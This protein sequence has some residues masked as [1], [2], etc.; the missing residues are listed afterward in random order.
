MNEFEQTVGCVEAQDWI[1]GTRIDIT[2]ASTGVHEHIRTCAEC[3]E[4]HS[5]RG[6]LSVDLRNLRTELNEVPPRS[7]DHAVLAAAADAVAARESGDH[8]PVQLRPSAPPPVATPRWMAAAAALLGA[9][10][11]LGFVAGRFTATGASGFAGGVAAPGPY[12]AGHWGHVLSRL[13]RHAS[14]PSGRHLARRDD[15][16]ARRPHLSN[17]G[18]GWR[19][20]PGGRGRPVR[21]G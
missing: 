12:D 20:V 2:P 17:D 14:T 18:P 5:A 8:P 15:P 16:P 10:V 1:W 6:A 7:L 4:E 13:A 3:R 19:P 9:A 21:R 11:L